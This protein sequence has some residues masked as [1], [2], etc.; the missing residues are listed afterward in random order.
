MNLVL[1]K[2]RLVKLKVVDRARDKVKPVKT[3]V[4]TRCPPRSNVPDVLV[5]QE[6]A[7]HLIR[8]DQSV[9]MG[10]APFFCIYMKIFRIILI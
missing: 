8:L 3:S 5:L 6:T 10:Y 4:Q 1:S 7:N 2:Q 9:K